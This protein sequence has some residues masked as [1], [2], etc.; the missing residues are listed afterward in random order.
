MGLVATL[1]GSSCLEGHILTPRG[2][3]GT[4]AP[5]YSSGSGEARR[6]YTQRQVRQE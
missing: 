2:P 1:W 4:L 3:E 5:R 6:D